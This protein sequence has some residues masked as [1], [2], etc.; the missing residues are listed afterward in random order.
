MAQYT[1]EEAKIIAFAAQFVDE[2]D[3][4]NLRNFKDV[5]AIQT[6]FIR[7]GRYVSFYVF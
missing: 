4:S 2:C 6:V 1:I 7:D 5:E 3:K